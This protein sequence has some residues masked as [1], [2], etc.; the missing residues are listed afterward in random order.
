MTTLAISFQDIHVST[1]W[2]LTPISNISE[3]AYLDIYHQGNFIEAWPLT[4]N[5]Q[6][7]ILRNENDRHLLAVNV[8][9]IHDGKLI[10]EAPRIEGWARLW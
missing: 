8:N 9:L 10:L 6:F 2:Q 3:T 5:A 7:E 1:K 4:V